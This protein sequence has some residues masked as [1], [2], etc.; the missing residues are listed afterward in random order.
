MG[1]ADVVAALGGDW[2]GDYGVASC[3]VPGHGRGRGDR[4]PS[5][6]IAD[7]ERGQVLVHCFAGCDPG[8]VIRTLRARGVSIASG[9]VPADQSRAS[10]R[11]RSRAAVRPIPMADPVSSSDVGR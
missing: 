6:S 4:R 11:L 1:A 9:R 3:P 7:G 10:T 8:D 2:R 5:L